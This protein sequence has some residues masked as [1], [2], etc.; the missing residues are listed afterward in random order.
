MCSVNLL[1]KLARYVQVNKGHHSFPRPE[2]DYFERLKSID[3]YLNKEVHSIVNQG[4]A[5][6]KSGWLTDHGP[7][8]VSTVI[9]RACDMLFCRDSDESELTPYECYI[10]F[11][12]IHMHDV[13]NVLGREEHEKK[14]TEAM[15]N[16]RA[17]ILGDDSL[18]QRLIRDIATAHGG[19]VDGNRDTIGHL[20]YTRSMSSNSPRVHLL[21]SILRFA[22]EL[23]DDCT[24]T[25]RF[26]M[27][28]ANTKKMLSGSEI[29]HHY[30]DRLRSV[31]PDRRDGV[32]Y[33]R[34]E[35]DIDKDR[36]LI[37]EKC[38]KG[39][40]K[41]YLFDEILERSLKLHHEHVY[42]AKYMQPFVSFSRVEVEINICKNKYLDI[43]N[44]MRFVMQD[45]AY[46]S[47]P[48]SLS[49]LCPELAGVSGAVLR[50]KVT[51][52]RKTG[53]YQ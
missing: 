46:P 48:A 30:A 15:A 7:E 37:L 35:L 53:E 28:L 33:L 9:R 31:K 13:G 3:G 45:C 10:L 49:A 38:Q 29:Y 19:Y 22:D 52:Y 25:K 11:L 26:L 8:H 1:S 12:A 39:D 24:R 20:R 5:A 6:A 21:A 14:I 2:T 40:K 23:A 43:V 27:N 44:T 32:V 17:G 18:E 16:I 42:C 51:H 36:E 41:Q 4:A 34:F 50:K 47:A